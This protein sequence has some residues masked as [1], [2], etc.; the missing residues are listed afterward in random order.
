MGRELRRAIADS[1]FEGERNLQ[2]SGYAW[3]G[4]VQ[5]ADFAFESLVA[6][7]NV[8]PGFHPLIVDTRI[9][10]P[11]FWLATANSAGSTFRKIRQ[12]L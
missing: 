2:I 7:L 10:S 3:D 12:M 8:G 6:S 4:S 9:S 1:N 11:I 5:L